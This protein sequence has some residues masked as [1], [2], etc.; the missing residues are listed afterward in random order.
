[1]IYLL[2]EGVV[3]PFCLRELYMYYVVE[4]LIKQK[5]FIFYWIKEEFTINSKGFII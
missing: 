4:V 3:N 5:Y 2:M 1:M